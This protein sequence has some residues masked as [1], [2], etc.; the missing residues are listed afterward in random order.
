MI[1]YLRLPGAFLALIWHYQVGISF[2][3]SLRGLFDANDF[4]PIQNRLL[5]EGFQDPGMNS[6][7]VY[8]PYPA[9]YCLLHEGSVAQV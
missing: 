4:L 8:I 6:I 2:A 3:I 7:F 5:S 9:F 1:S